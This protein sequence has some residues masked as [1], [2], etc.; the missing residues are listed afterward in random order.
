[1]SN[2]HIRVDVGRN[3]STPPPPRS[4]ALQNLGCL[5]PAIPRPRHR[6]AHVLTLPR[7]GKPWARAA[8]S[9][10]LQWTGRI[11]RDLRGEISPNPGPGAPEE[12]CKNRRSSSRE[13]GIS[14]YQH[15]SALSILVRE[16]CPKK[17]KRALLGELETQPRSL[18]EDA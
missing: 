6:T 9:A 4:Q 17:G 5:P 2:L 7:L 16:P 11:R 12:A 15:F 18:V 14:W 8:S 1:M 3:H 13:V 10:S